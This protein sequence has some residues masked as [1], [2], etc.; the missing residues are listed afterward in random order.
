M[1]KKQTYTFKYGRIKRKQTNTFK[2]WIKKSILDP[3]G[4][5]DLRRKFLARR[6]NLCQTF[7]D[8]SPDNNQNHGDDDD[9]GGGECDDVDGDNEDDDDAEDNVSVDICQ[10]FPDHSPISAHSFAAKKVTKKL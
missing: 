7:P 2:I 5:F 4:A 9:G 1:K 6:V 8:H 10:T 3:T